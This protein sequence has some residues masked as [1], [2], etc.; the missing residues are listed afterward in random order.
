MSARLTEHFLLDELLTSETAARRGIALI[1]P[2]SIINNLQRLC[3]LGL[4][5][6]RGRLGRPVFV[7]SGWRPEWLNRLVGGSPGSAHMEGRA[8]DIKVEGMSARSLAGFIARQGLPF[9]KVIEEFDRWVHVQIPR[10]GAEPRGLLLTAR[11][12]NGATQYT[13]GL[14]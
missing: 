13:E 12:V 3:T 6:L 4:E 8:G 1:P 10:E 7:L 14:S 5:P 2:Q 11:Y 9:D